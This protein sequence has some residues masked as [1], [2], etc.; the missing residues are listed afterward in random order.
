MFEEE[1]CPTCGNTDYETED[2][3]EEF[4]YTS[5]R[6]LCE[7][8]CSKCGQPFVIERTYNLKSVEVSAS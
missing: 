5:A 1:K 3:Y 2:Y 8:K 7:C 4:D 6:Q